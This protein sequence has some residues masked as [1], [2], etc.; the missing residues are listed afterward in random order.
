MAASGTFSFTASATLTT[1]GGDTLTWE[2]GELSPFD[3]QTGEG[4]PFI[5]EPGEG[6]PFVLEP[7]IL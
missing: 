6:S 5:I 2:S 3:L 7:S 1:I 4:S